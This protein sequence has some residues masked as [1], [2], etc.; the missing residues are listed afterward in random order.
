M[1]AA[2]TFAD[3]DEVAI[4]VQESAA[5][6]ITGNLMR[7]NPFGI[8]LLSDGATQVIDNDINGG[9][10]GIQ[11][12]EQAMPLVRDNRLTGMLGVGIAVTGQAGGTYI[13]NNI[14]VG[15]GVGMVADGEAAPGHRWADRHRWR[16]GCRLH[17]LQC[18]IA[19][20]R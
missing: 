8:S 14:A 17:R 6:V 4:A 18:R 20:E 12:D 5:P 13:D 15:E 2:N 16:G 10:V 3:N 9:E 19:G 11:V 1:I 7:S